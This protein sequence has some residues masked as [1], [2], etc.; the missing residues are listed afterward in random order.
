MYADEH[1]VPESAASKP[2]KNALL[3][4]P[5]EQALIRNHGAPCLTCDCDATQRQFCEA[6]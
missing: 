6:W 2:E 1:E 5:I 3:Y 4:T